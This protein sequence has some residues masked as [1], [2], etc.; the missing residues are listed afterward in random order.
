MKEIKKFKKFLSTTY[1]FEKSKCVLGL[2]DKAI[3]LET[4]SDLEKNRKYLSDIYHVYQSIQA[5]NYDDLGN[6]CVADFYVPRDFLVDCEFAW[7]ANIVQSSKNIFN[8]S[9][10]RF[11]RDGDDKI[12]IYKKDWKV[13]VD[14]VYFDEDEGVEK[15][16]ETREI[17]F[18]VINWHYV[19]DNWTEFLIVEDSDKG[20]SENSSK[21]NEIEQEFKTPLKIKIMTIVNEYYSLQSLADAIIEIIAKKYEIVN[22]EEFLSS[23]YNLVDSWIITKE[24]ANNVLKLLKN[25]WCI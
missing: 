2:R 6:I 7:K 18:K 1:S 10:S 15:L 13:L 16:R 21:K 23:Y 24:S 8:I 20:F 5:I 4:F 12:Y 11:V 25:N 17:N 9:S 14:E 19:V 22:K 3:V